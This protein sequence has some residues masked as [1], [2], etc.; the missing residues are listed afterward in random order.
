MTDVAAALRDAA[1]R[2]K[3]AGCDT[4][5]LDAVLLL[6]QALG[7]TPDRVRLSPD[8]KLDADAA[9]RFAAMLVRRAAR[10]PV[11]HILGRREFW[12]LDF[13]VSPAVLDP[14]P[15]SETLVQAVL[16][17][18]PDRKAALRLVDFG[19][20]SG[21]LLLALLHE[22]PKATGLGVDAS[23][24]ALDVAR[25]NAARLGLAERAN[26]ML[27]DWGAG[28]A[29]P[30]DILISNPPYIE[31]A[32][33]AGLADDVRKHE[34]L[35][36][37]DGGAD[38]LDCYRRLIPDMARL[39]A[40]NAILALEVGQGQADAVAGLLASLGG[41]NPAGIARIHDLGGVARVVQAR[42][43]A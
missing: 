1:G 26:F 38:G 8:M 5:R 34:P 3:A 10:E 24:A 9:A 21:C 37:L 7:I 42:N 11:S 19:T 40:G 12:G 30:F 33:I 29:G 28:L 35:S 14:R 36:A 17:A 22:L 41:V 25:D 4:P 13:K 18:V 23:E 31:T 32:A 43:T 20:G 6:A 27:G 2:L 16:D 39:V 15:D